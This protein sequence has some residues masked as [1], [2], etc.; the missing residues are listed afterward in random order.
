MA[1]PHPDY[2]PGHPLAPDAEPVTDWATYGRAVWRYRWWVLGLA[3]LGTLGGAAATRVLPPRYFAE[4]TIW[5]QTTDSRGAPDRGPL[6]GSQL[7]GAPAWGELVKSYVVLDAVVRDRHLYLQTRPRDAA[8]FANFAVRE[9]FRPGR[10]VL[11]VD[12][13]RRSYTLEAK[14]QAGGKLEQGNIGDAIGAAL[15][16]DWRPSAEAL[17]ADN[18]VKF[19]VLSSRHAATLLAEDLKVT[20]DLS[21]NF[22]RVSLTD[23][24][25]DDAAATVNAIV[26]RFVGVATEMRRAKL[27]DLA[28][29]LGEQRQGAEDNLHRAE[30]ALASFRQRTITLPPDPSLPTSSAVTGVANSPVNEYF[31][32]RFEREEARTDRSAILYALASADSGGR[33]DALSRIRAVQRAPDLAAAFTELTAKRAERRA[34][35]LR[36]TDDHPAV[37]RLAT[38]IATLERQTIPGLA[39]ALANDLA[40]RERLLGGQLNSDSRELA[41]IP[42]RTIEEARL[43]REVGIAEEL[44]TA[45]QQR[46]NEARL[47]EASSLADVRVLDAA[48]P[49]QVPV[50]NMLAR[51]LAIGLVAGLGL[52][53]VGAV[54]AERIDP[55]IRYP[56]QVTNQIGLPILG[57]LPHVKRRNGNHGDQQV[58][59]VLEAMRSV[60]LNLMHAY[61]TGPVVTTITSPGQGDGKSFLTA[62]LALT[63]AHAGQR[64]VMVDG[65]TRRGSL[66]RALGVSRKPGLTDLLAGRVTLDDALQTIGTGGRPRGNGAG[67]VSQPVLHFLGAGSRVHESP[68]LLGS[69]AMVQLLVQLRNR[70]QIVLVDS[71]PFGAGVDPYTLGTLTGSMIVVLRT[72]I[73]HLAFARSRIAML[74]NLP[75]RMLGVVLNDVPAGGL[76]SYYSYLTGYGTVDER[77]LIQA[78]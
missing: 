78:P 76:Y 71:P 21:G 58:V 65:D 5:I 39:Q 44:F 63:F 6:G 25:G 10:Y 70:F 37:R 59:Q 62:N 56:Y 27:T 12:P 7:L 9:P 46:F 60:R 49:P 4:A 61:G 35:L 52:G 68:E 26:E 28:R 45:V 34:M 57:A 11:R 13:E 75:I 22:L 8:V 24:D 50:K 53:I 23:T 41:Q 43:R 20:V 17:L 14:G 2:V 15:G 67:G 48:A 55:K 18:D 74:Q 3:V 64:T 33:M 40:E 51:L 1:P 29:L 42:Q 31:A 16:F 69:P 19:T 36:Y 54:L 30:G 32:R 38:D 73:T 47:A 66:H 77:T 72:G